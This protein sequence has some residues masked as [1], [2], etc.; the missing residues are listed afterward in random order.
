ITKAAEKAGI[1]RGTHYDW[2]KDPEYQPILRQL[3]CK[4]PIC[5]T[6]WRCD[7]PIRPRETNHGGRHG[8]ATCIAARFRH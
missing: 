7:E 3:N 2:L 1:D 5:S 8:E 6:I 4:R